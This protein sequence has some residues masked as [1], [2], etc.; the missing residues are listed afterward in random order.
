M[1]IIRWFFGLISIIVF[2]VVALGWYSLLSGPTIENHSVLR[3][4]LD[5]ALSERAT[6]N[7]DALLGRPAPT[8]RSIT[9]SIRRAGEDSRIDGIVIAIRSPE[10]GFAQL[11]EIEHA[12]DDF[13][14]SG[15]FSV[16]FLE[17]AGEMQ[18]GDGA[19]ALATT[20]DEV[21]LAPPGDIN[22][23]GLHT[24]PLFFAGTLEK[25]GV[26]AHFEK[27]KEYKSA[28]NQ[29]TK[30]KMTDP[31]RESTKVLVD[32]LQSDLHG[33]LA[34]RRDQSPQHVAGWTAKGPYTSTEAL[35]LGLVDR[36]A[37]WDELRADVISRVGNEDPFVPAGAY[38]LEGRPHDQGAPIALI[39]GEGMVL[40]GSED[41]GP[42]SDAVMASD[43]LTYAFRKAREA[44]VKAVVF[45][46]DSPGGSY[47]ASDLIRREVEKT[48]NAGIPV[49]V[50]MGNVAASG[51]Y[52]VAMD[53]NHIIANPA[54]I[55][56]SIGVYAGI[57]NLNGLFENKLGVTHDSYQSAPRAEIF[58]QLEPLTEKRIAIFATFA[59]RVYADFTEK[60]ASK[61]GLPLDTID[62][63]AKGRVW[64]G[65]QALAL[66]LVDELGDMDTAISKARELAGLAPDAPV[67]L[68]AYPKADSP[69]EALRSIAEVSYE[70]L[71]VLAGFRRP[72]RQLRTIVEAVATESEAFPL[73]TRVNLPKLY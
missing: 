43:D 59:D 21:V 52:F 66:G 39:F 37:Y 16:A 23:I 20:A 6:L 26:E 60:V 36:L 56:G 9:Q 17:T 12:M 73:L 65:A 46:I 50:T 63:V 25:L 38:W 14:A 22:L 48:R 62:S 3:I 13:R 33:L 68:R 15:K 7:L 35:E 61:R 57:M 4:L 2:F 32:A 31:Q 70:G 53:A 10:I 72:A 71:G 1:R 69:L 67:E 64:T 47:I 58:S 24:E 28:A 41:G 51:G 54:T 44:E 55:T 30:K 42:W 8:L 11:Q 40:R 49:V 34:R 27:R 19:Y 18:R 5:G 29:F 45:R